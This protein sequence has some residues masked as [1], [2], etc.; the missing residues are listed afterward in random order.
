MFK[1]LGAIQKDILTCLLLQSHNLSHFADVKQYLP[2]SPHLSMVRADYS[3]HRLVI[4]RMVTSSGT[5]SRASILLSISRRSGIICHFCQDSASTQVLMTSQREGSSTVLRVWPLSVSP[6][7]YPGCRIALV[8]SSISRLSSSASLPG[9]QCL[10]M[11][12]LTIFSTSFC[13]L[14]SGL[15]THSRTSS[16]VPPRSASALIPPEEIPTPS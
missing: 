9:R 6:L 2:K 15:T 10:S 16:A 13:V 12:T 3:P 4:L 14:R 11:I 5:T 7:I 8:L 1:A